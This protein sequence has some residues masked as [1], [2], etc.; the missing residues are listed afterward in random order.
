MSLIGHGT[1]VCTSSTRPNSPAQGQQIFETDT[2]L[3]WYYDGAA[4]QRIHPA[5]SVVQTIWTRTDAIQSYG[6]TQVLG[7]L[8]LTIT[9]R[10]ASSKI[11]CQWVVSGE[12]AAYN[13][14][15]KVTKNDVVATNPPGYNSSTGN[16]DYSYMSMFSYE[17]DY[18]STPDS[19][20]VFYMDDAT[21]STASRS[22]CLMW[23][24]SSY[25][26]QNRSINAT[27]AI[28]YERLVSTGVAMEIMS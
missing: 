5:G 8:R 17:S 26:M 10:Y 22:Y 11:L 18:N 4:W 20:S 2:K 7:G 14:G 23:V 16:V 1:V 6:S 21:Y 15:F 13:G 12:A 19:T 9:P 24:G 3:L 25:F 27:A 28:G